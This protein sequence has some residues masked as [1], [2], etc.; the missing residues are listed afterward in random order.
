MPQIFPKGV[1]PLARLLVIGLPMMFGVTGVGL[2]AFY[3][4]S[5][6]TGV[7]E[8]PPQPVAF[9]HMHHV[10]QL[11][12]HCLYCHTSVEDSGFANV[13]PSKTCMNC[14]QQMWTS[15]DLLEPVRKSYREDKP[16]VWN[17]VHNV[18]HYAYFNHSIHVAKGV[19]CQSCHGQIDQ[20]NL[21]TQNKT[22]LMEWCISCHRNPQEN[23]RPKSEVFSMT[24]APGSLVDNKEQVWKREDLPN[25]GQVMEGGKLVDSKW[26]GELVG[27]PR[28]KTQAEL[29]PVLKEVYGVRD[30]V[31]LTGC[32]M[33]HR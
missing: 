3:R 12:I 2:A 19:G 27:K 20:M 23:L 13:P 30:A 31:T 6:A 8:T 17:R 14:H 4:S 18:P 16:I 32:S 21:T 28:P 10:G 25:W 15:A 29:G 22:L 7:D 26:V 11:G 1:N 33:C 24:W 5:Y 9:S